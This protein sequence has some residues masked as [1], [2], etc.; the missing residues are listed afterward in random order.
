MNMNI[1]LIILDATRADHLSCY[2]YNRNTSPVIDAIA[3]EGVLY[4]NAISP[5]PWTL[6]AYSSILTGMFPSKHRVNR[7]QPILDGAYSTLPE[8]LRSSGYEV[9]GVSNT[10]WISDATQFNRGFHQFLKAWQYWQSD[11]DLNNKRMVTLSNQEVGVLKDILKTF[12]KDNVFKNLINA[13]YS[14]FL[15]QRRDDGANRVNRLAKRLLNRYYS[16]KNPFFMML[17]Y[18]E[19]HL[20]YHPPGK[21]KSLFLDDDFN[22]HTINKVNQNAW[23][24]ICQKVQMSNV[25]FAILRALYDAE[26]FYVDS[27]IGEIVHFLKNNQLLDN[28][29]LIIT[30]DH[31]ENIGEHNLMDHQYCLYDTLLK[32]PLIIR[33][34]G[35]FPPGIRIQ[36]QVQT[37]DIFPTILDILDASEDMIFE[38]LQGESLVPTGI[39]N[40]YRDFSL[41]EYLV[42]QPSSAALKKRYPDFDASQFDRALK[43]IRTD[44]F[45]Y[46]YASDGRDEL[47]NLQED[48][49]ETHNILS[50][51][52]IIKDK[53]KKDLLKWLEDFDDVEGDKISFEFNNV[54]RKKL[55]GLGY[56]Q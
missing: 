15:F 52:F 19:P 23:D 22:V 56:L 17:H 32:V 7:H 18:L 46:I 35:V 34:P 2:G 27:R 13:F 47:Y 45:K 48:P 24:Y 54:A 5:A 9:F 43:M 10:V 36:K 20:K 42:P 12:M 41:A 3:R 28:T 4:E 55:E 6:P 14:A 21:Y 1:L 31:G 30:A 26:I 40:R 53:F 11:S 16:G 33:Y 37:L 38:Q 39:D 25:D 51:H 49:E 50:T 44:E 29:M 8:I